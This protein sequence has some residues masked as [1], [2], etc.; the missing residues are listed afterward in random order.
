M[1]VR[2]S[3]KSRLN[4]QIAGSNHQ[5]DVYNHR[6]LAHESAKSQFNRQ[7]VGSRIDKY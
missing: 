5:I 7:N 4:R 1:L 3:A 2:Q 6:S